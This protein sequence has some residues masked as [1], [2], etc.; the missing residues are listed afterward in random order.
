MSKW[1]EVNEACRLG[2]LCRLAP[3]R[4]YVPTLREE[5]DLYVSPDILAQLDGPWANEADEIRWGAL[6]ADLD[7]FIG[8]E[9][10]GVP[11]NPKKNKHAT[12]ARLCPP[13]AGLW[14]FRSRT[15]KPGLRLIGGFVAFNFFV[16]LIWRHRL[17]LGHKH[18]REWGT[19]IYQS[20]EAWDAI[21]TEPPL[22]A[23]DY[24]YA[25]LSDVELVP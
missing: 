23:G 3:S 20:K 25:Y 24:P 11:L 17:A 16:A 18:S 13:E 4:N 5:R 2:A 8:G 9:A 6:R 12:M 7:S 14:E 21:F 15:P 19:A 1:D 22:A 10:V